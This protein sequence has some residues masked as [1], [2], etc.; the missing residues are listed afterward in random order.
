MVCDFLA[1]RSGTR[2]LLASLTMGIMP[3]IASFCCE[4]GRD[5]SV[6][7]PE[8]ETKMEK[9]KFGKSCQRMLEKDIARLEH[10]F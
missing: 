1:S 7:Y 4:G 2:E 10:N 6:L 5:L 3:T 8:R 9:Q